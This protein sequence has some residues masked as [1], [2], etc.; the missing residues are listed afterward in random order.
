MAIWFCGIIG[1]VALGMWSMGFGLRDKKSVIR[2]PKTQDER[3]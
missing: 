2:G 1:V 3:R